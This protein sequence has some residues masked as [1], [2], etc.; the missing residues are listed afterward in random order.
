[1]QAAG[2]CLPPAARCP[3]GVRMRIIAGMA[4]GRQLKTF[5]GPG[6]RPTTDRV[7]ESWFSIVGGAEGVRFLDLYAGTGA[8]GIEALSRGAARCVLVEKSRPGAD[9]IEQN[10]ALLGELP[11]GATEVLR[12]DALFAMEQLARQGAEFDL[13]FADPPYEDTEA[14][15]KVVQALDRLPGLL[16]GGGSLTVQHARRVLLPEAAGTL[17]RSDERVYGDTVLT[18]YEA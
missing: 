10:L 13:I 18:F 14:P 3:N 15:L 8:I 9:V 16:A 4:R 11:A 5:K 2:A 17:R 12:M 6:V 7:R 1:M